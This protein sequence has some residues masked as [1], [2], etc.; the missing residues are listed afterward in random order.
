MH[1][2]LLAALLGL[3]ALTAQA[4]TVGLHVASHHMSSG[5]YNNYNPGLYWRA[6]SG[7]TVGGY[8]NS[9]GWNSYYA[10]WTFEDRSRAVGLTVGAVSGY[11][12]DGGKVMPLVALSVRPLENVRITFT[13]KSSRSVSVLHFSLETRL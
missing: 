9:H 8:R 11:W 12:P 13:P 3:A 10:G 5:R 2:K 6:D 7:L 4:D 1:T